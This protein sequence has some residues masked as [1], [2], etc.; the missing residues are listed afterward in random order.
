[1]RTWP[2][3]VLLF[4]AALIV[5]VSVVHFLANDETWPPPLCDEVAQVIDSRMA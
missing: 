1:V 4:A 3:Y 2:I 5:R